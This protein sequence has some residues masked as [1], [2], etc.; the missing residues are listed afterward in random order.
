MEQPSE[1]S[2]SIY[3]TQ[4]PAC[5]LTRIHARNMNAFAR[6]KDFY[7]YTLIKR[8]CLSNFQQEY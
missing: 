5:L 4:P 2:C 7:F 3:R 8:R 1:F 6:I